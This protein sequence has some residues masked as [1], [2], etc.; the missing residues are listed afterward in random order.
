MDR[1]H[2]SSVENDSAALSLPSARA[3]ADF[4]N[5]SLEWLIEGRGPKNRDPR[6]EAILA[7]IYDLPE[8]ERETYLRLIFARAS[9]PGAAA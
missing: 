4:H 7:A 2:L 1:S 3:L 5:V 6:G 9:E 8:A